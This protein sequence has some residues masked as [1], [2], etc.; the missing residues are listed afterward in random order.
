MPLAVWNR[1][2]AG[3]AEAARAI[4]SRRGRRSADEDEEDDEEEDADARGHGVVALFHVHGAAWDQRRRRCGRGLR[5][6]VVIPHC[7][8]RAPL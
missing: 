8:Q 3:A 2:P 1:N 7:K 6:A 4:A 5:Q